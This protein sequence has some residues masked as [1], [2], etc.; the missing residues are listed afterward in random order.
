MRKLH[1]DSQ[2]HNIFHYN[3]KECKHQ[4]KILTE[5]PTHTTSVSP[6]TSEVFEHQ[7]R[8]LNETRTRFT[9]EM[10]SSRID[11]KVLHKTNVY[12]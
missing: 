11:P 3:K 8:R 9:L 6:R 5:S 7:H 2:P 4:T 1:G 10:E 12:N